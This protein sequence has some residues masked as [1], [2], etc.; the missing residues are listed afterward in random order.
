[1][2]GK[3]WAWNDPERRAT[4]RKKDELDLMR[5][6]EA[7]PNLRAELPREIVDQIDK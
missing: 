7:F 1:M 3:V 4:K 6:A 2:Q 5:I